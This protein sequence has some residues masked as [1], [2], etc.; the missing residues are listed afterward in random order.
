M[1]TFIMGV[2]LLSIG[3]LALCFAGISIKIWAKKDGEFAGT[4]ASNNPML[5]E[6][7]ASCGLCGAKPEEQC[8]ND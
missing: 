6:E 7:G 3:L 5:Q 8:L 4:C 1:K 2:V